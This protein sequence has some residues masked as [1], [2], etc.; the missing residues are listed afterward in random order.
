MFDDLFKI[1]GLSHE[2]LNTLLKLSETGSLIKAANDDLGRQSRLSHHVRELS[3]Y[4]GI[5]LT[6]KAGRSVKL[7]AAGRSL[8]QITREHF[9]ALQAFRSRGAGA[10]PQIHIAA[11]DSLLQW[12]L[13]PAIGRIREPN[14]LLRFTLS[15]L[16]TKD[17]VEQLN[18]RRIDLGLLRTNAVDKPLKHVAIYEQTYAIFVPQRLLPA[19]GMLTVRAALLDCPHASIGGDGQLLKQLGELAGKLGGTFIP[20]MVCGSIGQCVAAVES[21]VF[22]AVLPA[23]IKPS[24]SGKDY[25]VVEDDSLD[26][27]RREIA[28]AWHPRTADLTGPIGSKLR[29]S[30]VTALRQQ[31]ERYQ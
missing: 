30:L 22:A 12:L 5:E 19:R 15:S 2:R 17:I 27:L 6:E 23:Q 21:G 25:V 9:Q 24:S 20:E 11:G 14:N 28:L 7:T 4:F 18:E 31:S 26:S 3:E 29:Q 10:V 16:R 8:V 1:R 13:V